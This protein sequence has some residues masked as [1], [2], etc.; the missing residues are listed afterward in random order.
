M[1]IHVPG[2]RDRRGRVKGVNRSAVATLSLT[3]MVDMFTVLVIFLLMNYKTTGEVIPI[4]ENVDLPSAESVKELKPSNIVV[5]SLDAV[6]LNGEIVASMSDVIA[7][8]DWVIT[9]LSS[10]LREALAIEEKLRRQSVARQV[11][12]AVR[13]AKD[14]GVDEEPF[15]H[16]VT[17][18]ADRNLDILAL[19]KVMYTITDAGG[20][21]INFAVIK[22]E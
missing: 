8:S 19:K 4:K 14:P 15:F 17:I 5:V 18:Q 13:Q 16:K 9:G 10:R 22:E 2:K 11:R 12:E 3:A 7:A 1:P 21:A 20:E 6:E